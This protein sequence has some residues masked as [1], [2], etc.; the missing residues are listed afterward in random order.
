MIILINN[1][2]WILLLS[3][4]LCITV[5]FTSTKL[6]ADND[7]SISEIQ[8]KLNS[9]TEEEREI[10][11]FLFIQVQEID[12]L[13]REN[14]RITEDIESMKIDIENIEE[15]IEKE[16][17]SYEKNLLALESIL[18]S[19]QRMGPGSYLEIIIK[20]ENLTDFIHRVNILRDLTKNTG[21]LL[22][23]I[24]ESKETLLAEKTNLDDKLNL[25]E[26]KQDELRETIDKKQELV[27]EKEEYLESLAG[28]RELY[29][30][31]LE[32]LS[33]MMDEVKKILGEFTRG[34]AKIIEEGEFPE[35]AVQESITLKGIKGTIE[36]KVFNQV[37]NNFDWM[38]KLE[39]KFYDG[40]IQLKA[41]DKKLILSG[42]FEIEGGQILKFVPEEGSFFGMPL[43]KGTIEDLFQDGDFTL[44]FEPLIGK[45]I[46]KSVEIKEGYME[47]IVTLKLF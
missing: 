36:E 7:D 35:D 15:R 40:I 10:L 28:D 12:E 17:K 34:F 14:K 27:K 26:E 25:L 30:E 8:D 39:V 24:E 3:F 33:L 6:I 31:R 20:S 38:P 11:E 44:N 45:N 2:K 32:Y 16:E 23:T 42:K 1:R 4:I 46:L 21:D 43:E 19:Y 29:I 5:I 13:E 37:I 47:V 41:P 9:I 18:K 22:S